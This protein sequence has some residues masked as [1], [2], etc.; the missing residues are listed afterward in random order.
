LQL[1]EKLDEAVTRY[2]E[3]LKIRPEYAQAHYNLAIALI[4]QDKSEEAL[5]HLTT[6]LT[7]EPSLV[8][9]HP[10]IVEL[11]KSGQ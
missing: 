1:D 7:L 9:E 8:K 6:A 11:L 10:E 4:A 5:A 2:R 3:A